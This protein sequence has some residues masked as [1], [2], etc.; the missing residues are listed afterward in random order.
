MVYDIYHS[1]EGMRTSTRQANS[2]LTPIR[3]KLSS[4]KN[5]R[6]STAKRP[7]VGL[8]KKK[9]SENFPTSF[10]T[11]SICRAHISHKCAWQYIPIWPYSLTA[12]S[13]FLVRRVV[14]VLRFGFSSSGVSTFTPANS[15]SMRIRPQY[16][17]TMIFLCILMSS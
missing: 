7:I 3:K 11:L 1:G 15:G 12:S 17:Q 4:F 14:R 13:A 2:A 5:H 8:T 9:E 16:S 10:R 6:T